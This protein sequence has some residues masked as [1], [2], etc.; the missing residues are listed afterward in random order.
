MISL[1]HRWVGDAG[2]PVSSA[3]EPKVQVRS[4]SDQIEL[5]KEIAKY[6][7]FG[8]SR[9]SVGPIGRFRVGVAGSWR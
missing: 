2:A 8:S 3:P 9:I 1:L 7:K 5:I 6:R 4:S